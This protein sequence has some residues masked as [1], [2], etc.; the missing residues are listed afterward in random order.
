M[1][2]GTVAFSD[3]MQ[4]ATTQG[5]TETFPLSIG[6]AILLLWLI[7]RSVLATW[8]T[9]TVVFLSVLGGIGVAS[10]MD[11]VFQ[12]HL[13]SKFRLSWPQPLFR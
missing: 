2:T 13:V 4:Q 7:L 3:A 11:I 12:R 1:I 9:M 10:A 5:F 6:A 8:F